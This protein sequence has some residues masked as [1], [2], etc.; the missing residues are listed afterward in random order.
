MNPAMKIAG[1]AVLVIAAVAGSF[2]LLGNGGGFGTPATPSP[3][4]APTATV[5]PTPSPTPAPTPLDTSGWTRFVS[6]TYTLSLLHPDD[7]TLR[8]STHE[9]TLEADGA[10]FGGT[11][12]NAA[13]IFHSAD[14]HIGISAWSVAV[15]PGTTLEEWVAAYCEMNSAPCPDVQERAEP[16]V[17]EGGDPY[18]GVLVPMPGDIQVFF[19]TWYDEAASDSI[20]TQPAPADAR[21]YA[22]ATW[23]PVG[24]AD[25]LLLTEAF[26]RSLCVGCSE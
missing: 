16:I 1:A 7:W 10:E 2:Y 3:S 22:I 17:A 15:E 4:V 23:R 6:T 25:S 8:P 11:E 26:S 9:W 21:I 12:D 13:E 14:G 20:W 24:E 19:P 18:P 5:A